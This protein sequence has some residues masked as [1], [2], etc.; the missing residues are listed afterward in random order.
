MVDGRRRAPM[1]PETTRTRWPNKRRHSAA[2]LADLP[3]LKFA[4]VDTSAIPDI[5][6]NLAA[7]VCAVTLTATV[8]CPPFSQD[9]QLREVGTS[10]VL[11][12]GQLERI[13]DAN[14]AGK[15]ARNGTSCLECAAM[16]INPLAAER[17]LSLRSFLTAERLLG[18]Q[19]RPKQDSV[20]YAMMPPRLIKLRRA[21][22]SV[23]N[24]FQCLMARYP[25]SRRI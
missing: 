13:R 11:G 25:M 4:L 20:G 15:L 16:R 19:P 7:I 6:H 17:C 24:I 3:P 1:R 12:P 22:A 9:G 21:P 18:S 5:S 10:Q 14:A 8:S 2:V 23:A